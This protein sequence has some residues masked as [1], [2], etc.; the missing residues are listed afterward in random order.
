L[1]ADATPARD[2]SP[3]AFRLVAAVVLGS[4]G[5]A[6][7]A[8]D[9]STPEEAPATGIVPADS[10]EVDPVRVGMDPAVLERLDAAILTAIADSATPGAALAV[11]RHGRVVRLRGYGRLDWDGET[12]VTPTTLYDLASL[13]KVVGTTT[14]VAML[15]EDG[16]ID[17]DRP[18]VHYLP[19]WSGGQPAKARVTVRQLL[20]H[21]AGL[22]AF[23]P[24]FH[25]RSGTA[26]YREALAAEPLESSPG[27]TTL[28]SDLGAIT[29]G[30]LVEEVSGTPLDLFLETRVWEPLGMQDTAFR[31]DSSLLPRIAPTELDTLWRGF[32]VHG[33]V[34][35]ENAYAM[36]GVAGHAGLFSSALD[37][38]IF[39]R[40]MLAGG[41]V[42]PCAPSVSVAFPCTRTR[43]DRVRILEE[44]TVTRYTVRGQ[45]GGSRALGWDTPSGR[46]SAGDYFTVRAFGHT[47]F[48][49]TSIWLD[50]ELDLFVILLTTRV[51]PSRDNPRHIPLRRAVQD[52]AARA[53]VDHP[54]ER[55]EGGGG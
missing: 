1:G 24:W 40:M 33:V 26:A 28:Y 16:R 42:P 13:T 10:L 39:A 53:I 41:V 43:D 20:R 22:P 6:G 45:E 34:H 29:L 48:T 49:G 32:H 54:V 37:L 3:L 52:L 12:P 9:A 31:P 14:A 19:W 50:P 38:S 18:V 4:C 17:L 30:Y 27:T 23:R 11:G 51:D 55:R 5:V 2:R 15:D 21:R 35:D 25:E 47:G 36:G 46:S 8:G 44:E 7:G